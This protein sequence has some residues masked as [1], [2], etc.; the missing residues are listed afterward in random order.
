M[1][2]GKLIE[3]ARGRSHD[4]ECKLYELLK[5]GFFKALKGKFGDITQEDIEDLYQDSFVVLL[6]SIQGGTIKNKSSAQSYINRTGINTYL[7]T[8]RRSNSFNLNFDLEAEE[9]K[10]LL[11]K[12]K[13]EMIE[14]MEEL[15]SQLD[16]KDQLL[17]WA[18]SEKVPYRKIYLYFNP[19]E[20]DAPKNVLDDNVAA[21]RMYF[22]R[23]I[24]R[25]ANDIQ[26]R[27]HKDNSLKL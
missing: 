13:E 2:V 16:E 22:F 11:L 5:L 17:L 19:D 1:D 7:N 10:M 6:A 27:L 21:E 18:R 25:L 24:L 3:L 12:D 8:L 9:D 14:V 20:K 26:S 4:A 15:F 23:L